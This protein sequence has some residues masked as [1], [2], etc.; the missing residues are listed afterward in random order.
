MK[1]TNREGV[2][3]AAC[4]DYLGEQL[5]DRPWAVIAPKF[6]ETK[7]NGLQ[8]AYS[9][10]ANGLNV[11]RFDHTNHVGESG[12]DQ[13][14]FTLASGA[15]DILS[16]GD[17]LE[18]KHGVREFTLVANSLSARTAIRAAAGDARVSH[19]VCLVGVVNLR[20]TLREV[21]RDDLVGGHLAGRRWGVG[22]MLG[23][24]MDYDTFLQSAVREN[25]HDLAGTRADLE[26]TAA[27]IS[28]YAAER[29]TWVLLSDVHEVLLGRPR[30][31]VCII[32]EAMHELRENAQVA[33]RAF[34]SIV[35]ACVAHAHGIA[36]EAVVLRQPDKRQLLQQ[37][38]E[39]RERLR[40]QSQ[41]VE[42]ERD[43]WAKYLA[44][45]RLLH[46]VDDY[47][48]YLKLVGHLLGPIRAGD[49]VLDAGCG[50]GMF[51][52]WVIRTLLEQLAADEGPP[53]YV[54]LDLTVEGLRDA[55]D[56]HT[57]YSLGHIRTAGERAQQYVSLLYGQTDLDT[58]GMPTAEVPGLVAFADHCF[59]KACCSLVLSYLNRPQSVLAELHRVLKPGA[60]LVVSSMKPFCDLSEIYRDFM[61][62]QVSESELE[63]GRDLLRAAGKIRLKEEQG[64]YT[65]FSG[66]ELT[67]M[68]TAAGFRRC[69]THLSFG[70]QTVVVAAEK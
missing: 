62:Q 28:F 9:L 70:G 40:Q 39:E 5:G 34:R 35:T 46:T 19:I 7:K 20:H 2:K 23:V 69:E 31:Q 55:V 33:E 63:S 56:L 67:A 10:A 1:F 24:E 41:E 53:V 68:L 60:R 47:Q 8:L 18:K 36:P 54:G 27:K 44:K 25:L 38:R 17:Y 65:F 45:Y 14:Y 15:G 22:D 21:Y 12:G 61:G 37:N 49:I 26:R 43:F 32:P 30:T 51:G 52:I 64:Y 48:G 59:D 42:N 58:W 16:C 66:E 29:D 11:L 57:G 4:V 13:T 3:L 6:G 50:N